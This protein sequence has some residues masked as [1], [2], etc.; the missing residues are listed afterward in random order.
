MQNKTLIILLVLIVLF[1]MIVFLA[2]KR[3]GGEVKNRQLQS[4]KLN[5]LLK[6][7]L[8]C[9]QKQRGLCLRYHSAEV[10]L[11]TEIEQLLA[12][13]EKLISKA[14]YQYS[15]F[16][17]DDPHW[18]SIRIDWSSLRD[19]IFIF[20]WENAFINHNV[21]IENIIFMMENVAIKGQQVLE[22]T[23]NKEEVRAIWWNIPQTLEAIGKTRAIGSG[24]ASEGICS[25]ENKLK[26]IYLSDEIARNYRTVSS[27][28]NRI[29]ADEIR[30]MPSQVAQS[31][32]SF[33]IVVHDKLITPEVP[34]VAAD[35]FFNQATQTMDGVSHLFDTISI[36]KE[37]QIRKA[38]A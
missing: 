35:A 8:L 11:K 27:Q 6:S 34:E 13:N 29:A 5:L 15:R 20:D 2:K 33:L 1:M 17:N 23:L 26:L 28:L 14:E 30:D 36:I 24:V 32:D 21:L 22:N 18:R 9:I 3:V 31:I 12:D 19:N 10:H 25:R 38:A 16:L 37:R 7:L 4:I